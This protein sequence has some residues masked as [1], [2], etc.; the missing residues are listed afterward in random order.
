MIQGLLSIQG[1]C[2]L[3]VLLSSGG[4]SP[5]APAGTFTFEGEESTRR[6]ASGSFTQHDGPLASQGRYVTLGAEN[7]QPGT[8][9]FEFEL[10]EA[11]AVRTFVKIKRHVLPGEPPAQEIYDRSLE[12]RFDDEPWADWTIENLGHLLWNWNSHDYPAWSFPREERPDMVKRF[13]PNRL[14]RAELSEGKHRFQIRHSPGGED[15]GIDQVIITT[16]TSFRPQ[17]PEH[18]RGVFFHED[19]E[20]DFSSWLWETVSSGDTEISMNHARAGDSSARVELNYKGDTTH[21]EELMLHALASRDSERWVAFSLFLPKGGDEDWAVDSKNND[22]VFQVHAFPDSDENWR[23]PPISMNS[24]GGDWMIFLAVDGDTSLLDKEYDFIGPIWREPYETG[25]WTDWVYHFRFDH[26][27]EDPKGI[28]E[29][30]K[31]GRKVVDMHDAQIG[32]NDVG[33]SNVKTGVYKTRWRQRKNSETDV[34]RRVLYVDEFRVGDAAAELEDF[35]LPSKR[36]Q[37]PGA[38]RLP[39]VRQSQIRL[40]STFDSHW[41]LENLIRYAKGRDFKKQESVDATSTLLNDVDDRFQWLSEKGTAK[42][43]I[44]FEFTRPQEIDALLLWPFP[45]YDATFAW[46]FVRSYEEPTHGGRPDP[47]AASQNIAKLRVTLLDSDRKELY[48]SPVLTAEIP[49]ANT[50]IGA[51]AFPFGRVYA[52][53]ASA[54]VHIEGNHGGQRTGVSAL[55]FRVPTSAFGEVRE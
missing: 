53:V 6:G 3:L 43:E 29:V 8:L 34:R 17:F 30:W 14:W 21:R 49:P 18:R 1:R 22:I 54:V 37:P 45:S 44:R 40:S 15:V 33:A 47:G 19:F 35:A 20:A 42:G 50:R 36:V 10:E 2:F 23:V 24:S 27:K 39:I 38:K 9:T 12:V 32:Q 4:I 46:P 52:N 25:V 5:E 11:T 48:S 55:A 28:L 51:Q 13:G 31:D 7:K 16:D 41:T 26:R